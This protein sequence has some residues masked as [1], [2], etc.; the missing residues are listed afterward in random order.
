[1]ARRKYGLTDPTGEKRKKRAERRSDSTNTTEQQRIDEVSQQN[2][3][4]ARERLK[5]RFKNVTSTAQNVASA[6]GNA[7]N[8]VGSVASNVSNT[9]ASVS[10]KVNS[11]S[12]NDSNASYQEGVALANQYGIRESNLQ[13]LLGTDPYSAD[14][15]TPELSAKEA[16][17]IKLKLQRQLNAEEVRN[18]KI[19][20]GRQVVKNEIEQTK[21]IG[22]VV[23]LHTSRIDV[24]SKVITN[25]IAN[26][27]YDI[28]QSKLV[29]T[30]E[31]L[32]QQQDAT[33]GTQALTSE[34]REEWSLK[35]AAQQT[36]NN[37]LRLEI[38]GVVKDISIKRAEIEAR[39]LEAE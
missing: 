27:N 9:V 3:A 10:N 30:Q 32:V 31:L 4:K 28:N 34:F 21:L 38:E 6:V 5:E 13:S 7:V 1:M 12:S 15:T 33:T 39:L 29:Q 26:T 24:G 25:K 19:K 20:L 23:D 22:D 8:T 14:G 17:T 37:R 2:D 11:Q 18:S 35:L 16:S 36:K